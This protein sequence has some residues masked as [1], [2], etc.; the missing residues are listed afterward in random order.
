MGAPMRFGFVK[1][2]AALLVG[3]GFAIAQSPDTARNDVSSPSTAKQQGLGGPQSGAPSQKPEKLPIPQPAETP[4][5]PAV[6]ESGSG[7]VNHWWNNVF[8][9][10]GERG[11]RPY[12][13]WFG[14]DFLM[15]HIRNANLPS[16]TSAVPS[17]LVSITQSDSFIS[18]I[19]GAG[20]TVTRTFLIPAAVVNTP[21]IPGG[22][23]VNL[24]DHS[25]ARLTF[26]VWLDGEMKNG[27]ELSGFMLEKRSLN[28]LNTT[29][30]TNN[31]TVLNTGLANRTFVLPATGGLIGSSDPVVVNSQPIVFPAAVASQ[32]SGTTF[33]ELCGAELN[34]RTCGSTY[35][36]CGSSLAVTP[37]ALCGI[38]YL[39]FKE[40]LTIG[41]SVALDNVTVAGF[42]AA[43][44][45]PMGYMTVDDIRTKNSIV[46]PQFGLTLEANYNG[47]LLSAQ[48]KLAIGANWQELEVF[49]QTNQSSAAFNLINAPGGLL[50][51]PGD[52]GETS[53]TRVSVIPEFNLKLGK[54]FG[55]CLRMWVGYDAFCMGNVIRPGQ[56]TGYT[57][58]TTNASIN[59]G[60][61]ATLTQP[62]IQ[63]RDSDVWVQ[64]ASFGAEIRY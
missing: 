34:Y 46:A 57:T 27:V 2:L 39:R 45:L 5:A 43:P 35:G 54:E 41:N 50:S 10:L 33:A 31:Q 44:F 21:T 19:T 22:D 64:G 11:P 49:G 1:S 8:T 58:L 32:L 16:L 36:V 26:G 62:A 51:G 37:G 63:F 29:A 53:R 17:G 47:W 4:N 23:S 14:A 12:R 38:R 15:W 48:G 20:S 18:P 40:G 3:T 9:D 30:N 24:G 42:P 25:G 59:S 55:Q 13:V 52:Q 6:D 28:F 61:T 60:G 56:Q 7:E